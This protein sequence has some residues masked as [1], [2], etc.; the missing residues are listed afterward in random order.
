MKMSE[1]EFLEFLAFMGAFYEA[2]LEN[3]KVILEK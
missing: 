3:L 2:S 1:K